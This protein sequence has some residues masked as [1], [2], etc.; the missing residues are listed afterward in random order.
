M[1]GLLE[2]SSFSNLLTRHSCSSLFFVKHTLQHSV[3]MMEAEPGFNL[4]EYAGLRTNHR[5]TGKM[6]SD[7]HKKSHP[8]IYDM[9]MAFYLIFLYLLWAREGSN[10]RTSCV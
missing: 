7:F 9:G 10:L 3:V 4:P 6:S 5:R 8:Q 2:F 1:T